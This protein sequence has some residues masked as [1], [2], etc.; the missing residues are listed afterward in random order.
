[1]GEGREARAVR[2]SLAVI[3]P[4]TDL[5]QLSVV[6]ISIIQLELEVQYRLKSSTQLLNAS[7]H[8]KQHNQ[9]ASGRHA[10]TSSGRGGTQQLLAAVIF[11]DQLGHLYHGCNCLSVATAS[12]FCPELRAHKLHKA[13]SITPAKQ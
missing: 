1:M 6:L 13:K 8:Q 3:F 9:P 12:L 7:Q 5:G 10:I 11:H 4:R 2:T